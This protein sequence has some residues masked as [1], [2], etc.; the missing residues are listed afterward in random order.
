[1]AAM[2]F[3]AANL[4]W[5]EQ[6]ESFKKVVLENV[7]SME[8]SPGSAAQKEKKE[9]ADTAARR[10]EQ[11]AREAEIFAEEERNLTGWFDECVIRE[12]SNYVKQSKWYSDYRSW[13]D[14]AGRT[15]LTEGRAVATFKR[16]HPEIS[17]GQKTYG[18]KLLS[19]EPVQQSVT[20]PLMSKW[21]VDLLSTGRKVTS[22]MAMSLMS[23][24]IQ[25]CRKRDPPVVEEDIDTINKTN[26]GTSLK[27]YQGVKCD[28]TRKGSEYTFDC[29]E[30]QKCLIDLGHDI[31]SA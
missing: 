11:A 23:D 22:V 8:I 30:L 16:L 21:L 27:K 17:V 24:Y 12:A 15:P 6:Q 3:Q 13:A 10:A 18:I 28:T 14:R 26:F 7:I 19:Q 9:I 25:W 5:T 20:V 29:C 1:M 31:A 2:I 4:T